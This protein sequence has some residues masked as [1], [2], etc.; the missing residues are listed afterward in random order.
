[1]KRAPLPGP[2]QAMKRRI[3]GPRSTGLRIFSCVAIFLF[4]LQALGVSVPPSPWVNFFFYF[5]ILLAL[6]GELLAHWISRDLSAP[7]AILVGALA[8][9][10]AALCW[11]LLGSGIHKA[12]RR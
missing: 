1:M 4:G 12:L 6:P 8:P 9:F 5:C 7:D 10:L 11:A 3:T 2:R